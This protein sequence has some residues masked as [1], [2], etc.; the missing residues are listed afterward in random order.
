M[1]IYSFKTKTESTHLLLWDV[2][3]RSVIKLIVDSPLLLHNL[4]IS[5][6][7]KK[8]IQF[9]HNLGTYFSLQPLKLLIWLLHHWKEKNLLC[10]FSLQYILSSHSSSQKQIFDVV[11]YLMFYSTHIWEKIVHMTKLKGW[12]GWIF[13]TS[14]GGGGLSFF[15]CALGWVVFFMCSRGVIVFCVLKEG[16]TVFLHVCDKIVMTPPPPWAYCKT[17]NNLLH[18]IFEILKMQKL[19]VAKIT[20]TSNSQIFHVANFASS[21]V[22]ND[23]FLRSHN[24]HYLSTL[25]I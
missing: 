22:L 11:N 2:F 15:L 7:K 6:H 16:L 23:H 9:F 14:M 25:V 13:F 19:H 1:F 5:V 4:N 17:S 21:T 24:M 10:P 20:R 3:T 8:T 18:P 12:G